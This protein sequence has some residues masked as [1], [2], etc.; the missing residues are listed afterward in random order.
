MKHI[1]LSCR[2]C[3][4]GSGTLGSAYDLQDST[5]LG[6]RLFNPPAQPWSGVQL[7]QSPPTSLTSPMR[8]RPQDLFA[9]NAKLFLLI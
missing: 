9:P 2:I 7:L 1:R 8:R 5:Y 3:I 6:W 4:V